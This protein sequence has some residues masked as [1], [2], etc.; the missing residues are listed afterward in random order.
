MKWI[1]R[2]NLCQFILP[3]LTQIRMHSKHNY[4]LR[5]HALKALLALAPFG[6][7]G[8]ELNTQRSCDSNMFN[9]LKN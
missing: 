7:A 1:K 4:F 5:W 6:A 9:L 8:S 3:N 2:G